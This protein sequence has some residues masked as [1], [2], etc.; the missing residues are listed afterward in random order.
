MDPDRHRGYAFDEFVLD[1][2]RCALLRS[3]ND[4]GLEP[5]Q[6]HVL[7]LLVEYDGAPV[8]RD[9]FL[10]EVWDNAPPADD[11][12]E[13]CIDEIRR[14]IDEDAVQ[15]VDGAFS[16]E[17]KVEPLEELAIPPTLGKRHHREPFALALIALIVLLFVWLWLTGESNDAAL[18]ETP[19]AAE[20]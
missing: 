18:P 8:S 20:P 12:L 15:S 14:A 11:I 17:R 2:D 10:S 4:V 19:A 3:G 1:L 5:K 9:V 13:R 16:F 7:A 6:L